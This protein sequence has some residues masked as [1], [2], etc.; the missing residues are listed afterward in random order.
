MCSPL[1]EVRDWAKVTV[2]KKNSPLSAAAEGPGSYSSW[3]KPTS[4][5]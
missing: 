3:A 1:P 2:E 4:V 5:D